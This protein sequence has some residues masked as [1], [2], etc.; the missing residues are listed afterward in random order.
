MTQAFTGNDQNSDYGE[1]LMTLLWWRAWWKSK[2]MQVFCKLIL[3]LP[4]RAGD[5]ILR[6][7]MTGTRLQPVCSTVE[8]TRNCAVMMVFDRIPD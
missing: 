2:P 6:P 7:V 5:T 1:R 8:M 4:A 3:F